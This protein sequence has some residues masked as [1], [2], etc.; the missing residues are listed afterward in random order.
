[1]HTFTSFIHSHCALLFIFLF[2]LKRREKKTNIPYA[3][4]KNITQMQ[5][6]LR[7]IPF[8]KMVFFWRFHFLPLFMEK[9]IV[10]WICFEHTKKRIS[11]NF[12][13]FPFIP[14]MRPTESIAFFSHRN[15]FQLSTWST[16]VIYW[17]FYAIS[18]HLLIFMNSR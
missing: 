17:I 9:K 13:I 10:Y 5:T 11:S 1:M 15:E 3:Y 7:V 12:L 6:T 14:H 4:S 16:C 2:L 18:E 8:L